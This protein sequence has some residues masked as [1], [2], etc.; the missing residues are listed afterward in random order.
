MV[1]GAWFGGVE[2]AEALRGTQADSA[3][4]KARISALDPNKLDASL[5]GHDFDDV[6]LAALP[7]GVDPCGENGEFHTLA[8]DGP[9]FSRPLGIRVGETVLRDGFVFTD[10]LPIED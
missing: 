4:L 10:L 8:Y 7:E 9:M 2:E 6:L 1:A 5:G 3:G